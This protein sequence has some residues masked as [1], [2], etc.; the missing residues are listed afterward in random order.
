MAF[1]RDI[2][3]LLE[4]VRST[5]NVG[6]IFRTAEV[7]DINEIFLC[8]Y[9]PAPKQADDKRLPHIADK[10]HRQIKKTALGAEE[11]V[12]FR[13]FKDT[14]LAIKAAKQLGYKIAAL[15]RHK[16]S[17]IVRDYKFPDKIAIILGNEL[18]GVQDW[19]IS[20]CDVILEIE[21]FGKKES[22]NVANA[23]AI[24]MFAAR[25]KK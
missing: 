18:E 15:E 5:H 16:D 9:T 4:D 10:L 25:T 14:T 13:V 6:S 20:S 7:F 21:Q 24:A 8:G 19:T 1:K 12:K 17:V 2:I 3:L 23:A 11:L 22:L